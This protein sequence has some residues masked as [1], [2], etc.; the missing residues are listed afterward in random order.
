MYQLCSVQTA[1]YNWFSRR[2][3]VLV[4]LSGGVDSSVL[5]AVA[6]RSLGHRAVAATVFS[7]LQSRDDLDR[8]REVSSE[9]GIEHVILELE[10][11]D[12]PEIQRNGPLRC[13][14]CKY[15]MAELLCVEAKLRGIKTVVDGTNASDLEEDRPGMAALRL[16][17]I[18][19][20][21]RELG[22]TKDVVREIARSLGLSSAESPPRSCLATKIAGPLSPEVLARVES[23]VELL[24]EGA[25]FRDCGDLAAVELP[26]ATELSS[27]R[28]SALQK[29]GYSRLEI[30]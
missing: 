29:L 23:A 11:L 15:A 10:A 12:L 24:P 6:K 28:V 5:A 14:Y 9:L 13:Y 18:Q 20:P 27:M 7:E 30:R 4:A 16:H 8:A 17:K 25:R 22:I 21:L 26:P 3:S 1:L 2:K 19:M